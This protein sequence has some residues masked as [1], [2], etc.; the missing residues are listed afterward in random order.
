[1]PKYGSPFMLSF[2]VT[3]IGKKS[4]DA[5]TLN[6]GIEL[7]LMLSAGAG[8]TSGKNLC[9]LGNELTELCNILIIDCFY[10]IGTEG[11]NLLLS[12]HITEGTLCFISIHH[13]I[14][15]LSDS[16]ESIIFW[17]SQK[18]SPSSSSTVSNVLLFDVLLKDGA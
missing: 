14:L 2:S 9:T 18:G 3:Y 16:F 11:A 15:N 8:N 7:T 10:L 1:M 13:R 6:S 12:M 17:T 5:S 4:N